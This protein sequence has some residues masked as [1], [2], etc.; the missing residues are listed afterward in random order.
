MNI[1]I[2]KY[3]KAFLFFSLIIF[4]PLC[5]IKPQSFL[6][7]PLAKI[8][9]LSISKDEFLQRYEF[10]PLFG[11]NRKGMRESLKLEFLYSLI[12]EKLWALE[13]ENQ[14][15]DTT[16]VIKFATEEYEKMFVRDALFRKDIKSKI[17][18][19]EKEI[20]EGFTRKNTTL[21]V[22]YLI[23]DKKDEI[24]KLY[25]LLNQGIPFD[26]VLAYSPEEAE[27]KKPIEVVYGQM[28]LSIEDSLYNLKV[29]EYTSPIFTPDGWYIFKLTNKTQ[30]VLNTINERNNARKAIKK[31]IESRKARKLF[32]KYYYNFF[33]GKKVD[34]NTKLFKSLAI[35]LQKILSK[36]KKEYA[37]KEGDPVYTEAND[38][39]TLETE[40]GDDSLNIDFIQ[41]KKK[42]ITLRFFIRKIIFDSFSSVKTDLKTI[43]G[44]LNKQTRKIIEYELY[45]KK[46]IKEGLNLLPSVMNDLRMWKENYLYQDLLNKFTDSVKVT[47]K[48]L[49]TQY[50]KEYKSDVY[51]LEVNIIEVLTDSF[52]RAKEI[53]NKIKLG[54]DI[55]QL[56]VKYSKRKW[57][58]KN[59]GEFGYFPVTSFGK[60]GEIAKNMKIGEVKGPIKVRDGYS[61]FKLIGKRKARKKLP[62][63][64]AKVKNSIKRQI[65][66]NKTK[67]KITRYTFQLAKKYGISIDPDV[68]KSIKVTEINSFGFRY[69]GFGGRIKAAPLMPLNVDWVKPFIKSNSV[70]Q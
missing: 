16:Q 53:L 70:L 69:L 15:L 4:I 60:L 59:K 61:I 12:A 68:F 10:T 30:T 66:L 1:K 29:G 67:L 8:G 46:G 6:E 36:R 51:P 38:A 41:F 44:V 31:I 32:D 42:P 64:F 18:V 23:S 63:T 39:H 37:V 7:K 54:E 50:L 65:E 2:N 58:K 57:T 13:A 47:H 28:E 56:A 5:L 62:Q 9:N 52:S 33:K 49:Y 40:F 17:K 26:T 20:I 22:N 24:Y 14:R 45:S 55:K 43:L 25:N 35:K 34:V 48:E 11:K 21:D 27:Q 19:S 3:R